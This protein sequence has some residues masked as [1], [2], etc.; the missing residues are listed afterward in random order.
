MIHLYLTTNQN[1]YDVVGGII[2][3]EAE[4]VFGNY[5]PC[6]FI[7]KLGFKYGGESENERVIENEYYYNNGLDC[8][9]ENDWHEGQTDIIIY[10]FTAMEE[11][12]VK[13][14]IEGE[15]E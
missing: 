10:G 13:H 9:W 12:D 1:A 4:K 8:Y 14:E 3:K 15:T 6:A 7:V 2:D 11:V 5:N